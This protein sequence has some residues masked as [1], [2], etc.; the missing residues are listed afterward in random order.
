MGFWGWFRA[1]SKSKNRDLKTARRAA[2]RARAL[3]VESLEDRRVLSVGNGSSVFA[4]VSYDG[5]YTAFESNATNLVSGDTN[6]VMDIFV[7]ELYAGAITRASVGN[8]GVQGNARSY[9]GVISGNGRYVAFLSDATNLVTGDTNAATDVFIRD[10]ILGVTRRVSTSAAGTEA[11]A[12]SFDVSLSYD[13]RYVAFASNASNLVSGDT[14]SQADVFVKDLQTNLVT[15]VSVGAGGVQSNNPSANPSLSGDGRLVAFE[16]TASNL[17]SGDTNG[18]QD[19]F[20]RNIQSGEIRRMS[21][22]SNGVQ[23]NLN[24]SN[25]SLSGDGQLLVF[26]S[27]SSNLVANDANSSADIFLKNVSTNVLTRISTSSAGVEG[28]NSSHHPTIS[29]DGTGVAFYAAATNLVSGDTNGSAQDVYFKQ[30]SNNVTTRLSVSTAGVQGD[31]NSIAGKASVSGDGRY[32]VFDSSSTNLSTDDTNSVA[33]IYVRDRTGGTTTLMSQS[34]PVGPRDDVTVDFGGAG[35]WYWKDDTTY[36]RMHTYNAVRTIDADL[37]A[38]GHSDVVVDFGAGVGLWIF[39]NASTWVQLH[40]YTANS[41]VAGYFQAYNVRPQLFIDFGPSVGLWEYIAGPGTWKKISSSSVESMVVADLDGNGAQDL[42]CDL[43]SS[44]IYAWMN[45]SSWQQIYGSNPRAMVSGDFNGNGRADLA[46]DFGTGK[47]LWLLMDGVNWQFLHSYQTA[48]MTSGDMN[49]DGRDELVVD[50]GGSVGTY[51]YY[52][53][54]S[55]WQWL[56]WL[57]AESMITADLD[58][59]GQRELIADLGSNGLGAYR[60]NA[61]WS[62]LHNYNVDGFSAGDVNSTALFRSATYN[63]NA[64]PTSAAGYS[65]SVLNALAR[66]TTQGTASS[67]DST[68]DKSSLTVL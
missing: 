17:V 18:L 62:Y 1:R 29:Y 49:G 39:Y 12:G 15:R 27:D 58:G 5:R 32:V 16:S 34:A 14:N 55:N 66:E 3:R 51:E 4:S 22:D 8:G 42:V 35:L 19:I 50:F 52:Y 60:N 21:V 13:G 43:G 68:K 31:N 63:T 64:S 53:Q 41:M 54:T 36:V 56:M 2:L 20:L 65:L 37:D 46:V 38:S 6:A 45:D 59:N 11:N 9:D 33:D 26:E 57:H 23:G 61:A 25:P 30:L 40:T 47:G 7:K 44:G 48:S 24:S 67:L 10:L 28:D